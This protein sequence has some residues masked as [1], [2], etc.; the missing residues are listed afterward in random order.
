[1]IYGSL[2]MWGTETGRVGSNYPGNNKSEIKR[3]LKIVLQELDDE[4]C[5]LD[6]R[7]T[8]PGYKHFKETVL[9]K[10]WMLK[11]AVE[12]LHKDFENIDGLALLEVIAELREEL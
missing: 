7:N 8:F 10:K 3:L 9:G 11:K 1:M 2:D 6:N 12:N 5:M 4:Y